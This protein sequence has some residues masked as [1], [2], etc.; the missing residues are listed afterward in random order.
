MKYELHSKF[1]DPNDT[2]AYEAWDAIDTSPVVVALSDDY[3]LSHGLELS[4]R[5][6]WDPNKGIYHVKAFHHLHCLVGRPSLSFSV[7]S[8]SLPPEPRQVKNAFLDPYLTLC[9]LA[10]TETHAPCVH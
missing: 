3:A 9:P 4:V 6:P 8:L 1:N 5:F 10:Y 7:T 2:I